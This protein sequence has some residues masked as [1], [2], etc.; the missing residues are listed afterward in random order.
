MSELENG[1]SDIIIHSKDAMREISM[2]AY[3]SRKN[4]SFAIE[5]LGAIIA[6]AEYEMDLLNKMQIQMKE[7]S[8]EELE[9]F[10]KE[11]ITRC[12]NI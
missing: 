6:C 1:D 10:V 8:K 7:F 5:R 12:E 4:P 9:A 2:L 11:G 3:Y